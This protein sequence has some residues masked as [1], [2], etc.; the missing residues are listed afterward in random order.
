MILE[1]PFFLSLRIEFRVLSQ[2]K[3]F[4]CLWF[5]E[6]IPWPHTCKMRALHCTTLPT[7]KKQLLSVSSLLSLP[8]R[9][10]GTMHQWLMPVI[11]ATWED[12]GVRIWV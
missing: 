6:S 11:L 2:S 10:A 12:E 4:I 5:W 8:I 9:K 3:L 1:G 7:Q